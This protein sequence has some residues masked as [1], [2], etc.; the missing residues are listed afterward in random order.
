[1]VAFTQRFDL[2]RGIDPAIGGDLFEH[3][4]R[5][6][7]RSTCWAYCALFSAASPV[8]AV[9]CFSLILIHILNGAMPIAARGMSTQIQLATLF[10]SG[11]VLRS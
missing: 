4:R 7:I 1:V 6:S 2:G 3:G 8:C 10:M 5:A 11:V 9:I